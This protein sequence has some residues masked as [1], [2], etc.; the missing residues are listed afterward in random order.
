MKFQT[1]GDKA[2]FSDIKVRNDETVSI[3]QGT[4]VAYTM[5]GTEDGLAVVVPSTSNLKSTTFFAGVLLEDLGTD[6]PKLANA[7][8]YGVCDAIIRLATRAAT[9]DSYSTYASQAVG[10]RLAIDT[11]NDAF[12]TQATSGSAVNLPLGALAETIASQAGTAT[13]TDETGTVKTTLA[14]VFIRALG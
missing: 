10:V 8:A 4:P 2:N 13:S 9:S 14:K 6:V 12:I 7:R 11:L 1:L 5:D 3:P